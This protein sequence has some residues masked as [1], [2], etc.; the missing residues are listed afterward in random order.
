MKLDIL[1]IAAHPD[2]VELACAGTLMAHAAQ[3]LKV[4]IVD[5]TRGELGTRGTPEGRL[6]EAQD[7]A[8]ILGVEVRENLGL[9]DGFFQNREEEQLAVIRA[10]RKYKPEIVL[11]NAVH[12]RHPDH[13]RG[14]QLI[15][16]SCFYAGLRKIVT[17]VDGVPQEAWRP[18]QVYHFIQDRYI[19]PDFVVDISPYIEKKMEA[20]KAFKSQFLAAK[21]HEPQTYISS[22]GFF[23]SVI[24]RAKMMGKMVGVAYAEG[25]TTAKKL[26]VRN[27]MDLIHKTT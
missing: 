23:D 14:A 11:A 9:K 8:K 25:Y 21:D 24:Y 13:G 27:L 17:E 1:A 7:A 20:I 6:Q 19:E 5:L 12:D 10:I 22:E 2:D 18:K 26:G 3:G 16:D 4:G 15:T